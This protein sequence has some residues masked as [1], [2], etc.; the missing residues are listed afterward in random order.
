MDQDWKV[1]RM[2][3]VA[4]YYKEKWLEGDTGIL[5]ERCIL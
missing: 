5:K 2:Q 1:K 3:E 4:E